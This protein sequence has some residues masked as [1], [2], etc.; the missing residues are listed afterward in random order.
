M[1]A[2]I[3]LLKDVHSILPALEVHLRSKI[4]PYTFRKGTKIVTE[5]E[6]APLIL[7]LEKGL[8]RSYSMVKG[9]EANNY[10]MRE[11]DIIISVIAFFMQVAADESIVAEEDVEAWGITWQELEETFEKFVHFNI[12]G[13]KISNKYYC[14]SHLRWK[15]RQGKTP[16]EQYAELMEKDRELV[17]R[18]DVQHIRS[19]LDVSK[20]TYYRIR[21]NYAR[22]DRRK[23]RDQGS[24]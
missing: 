14:I 20:T 15:S 1:E 10:F 23:Q 11:G 2:L 18:V 3:R 6:M 5:G 4:K 22:R 13:R 9:K 8:I 12:H 17:S 16:E 19:Y 24:I 7:Y 21:V